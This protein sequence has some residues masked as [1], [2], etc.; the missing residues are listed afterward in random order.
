MVKG[1]IYTDINL[2]YK[3]TDVRHIHAWIQRTVSALVLRSLY[4]R[5]DFVDA[6]NA[7]NPVGIYLPL[8]AWFETVGALASILRILKESSNQQEM[9]E[10]MQP[11][12]LGNKGKGRMRVGSFEAKS[13]QTM[14]ENADKYMQEMVK[15]TKNNSSKSELDTYFTDYYDMASNPSHPSF[16]AYEIVGSL[17]NGIWVARTP[18]ESKNTIVD[19]LPA[20]GGLLMSPILLTNVCEKIFELEK[21]QFAKLGSKKYF[22]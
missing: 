9:F 4:V 8:K 18:E 19:N 6:V 15:E 16:E 11:Y 14:I 22:E 5:N 7:R 13:V 17:E 1:F 10:K 3:P 21:E 2:D 20:Y 12:A